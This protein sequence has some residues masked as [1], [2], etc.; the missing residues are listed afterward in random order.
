MVRGM[1]TLGEKGT[2][3]PGARSRRRAAARVRSSI[4]ASTSDAANETE[5][6]ATMSGR[7][8]GRVAGG[9]G[10]HEPDDALRRDPRRREI[11]T[12]AHAGERLGLVVAGDGEHH[13]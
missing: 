2:R 12:G 7:L 8:L 10:I 5:S 1:N 9:R 3:S 11:L 4:P 13:K 6:V